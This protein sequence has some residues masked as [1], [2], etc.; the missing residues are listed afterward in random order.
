ML[1][2]VLEACFALDVDVARGVLSFRA[3]GIEGVLTARPLPLFGGRKPAF[4]SAW[5]ASRSCLMEFTLPIH[6]GSLEG[7]GRVEDPGPGVAPS[8]CVESGR[9]CKEARCLQLQRAGSFLDGSKTQHWSGQT[10][11]NWEG[12]KEVLDVAGGGAG[13][14]ISTESSCPGEEAAESL[15]ELS[16]LD[17]VAE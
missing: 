12:Y 10:F 16:E 8:S 17:I 1:G 6:R 3:E 13:E 14:M 11:W 9:Q 4:T 2:P 7:E 5:A 15:D